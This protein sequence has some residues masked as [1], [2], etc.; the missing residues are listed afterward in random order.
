VGGR[1]DRGRVR[2]VAA[3]PRWGI[4]FDLVRKHI[5]NLINLRALSHVTVEEHYKCVSGY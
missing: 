5:L 4:C 2:V 3:G 1:V